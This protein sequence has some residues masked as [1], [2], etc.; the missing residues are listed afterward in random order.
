MAVK[1]VITCDLTGKELDLKEISQ[2]TLCT[3][4]YKKIGSVEDFK[5]K[6]PIKC[7]TDIEEYHFHISSEQAPRFMEGIKKLMSELKENK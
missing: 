1:Q 3:V 4:S 7:V 5:T 2:M 6:E